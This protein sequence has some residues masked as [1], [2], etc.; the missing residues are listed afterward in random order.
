[1]DK[2]KNL[3]AAASSDGIVVNSH[4]GRATTFYIYEEKEEKIRCIEKRIVESA[5]TG[6]SHDDVKLRENL[7]KFSDCRYLIVSRIGNGAAT[8]A[9]SLGIDVYEI[10]GVIEESIQQLLRYEK[11]KKLF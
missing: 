11:I 4:F 10:P 1:M 3:I 8:M 7:E 9:E 6:G 2:S 5:C